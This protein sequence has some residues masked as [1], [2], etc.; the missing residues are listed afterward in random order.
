MSCCFCAQ[1]SPAAHFHV[2]RHVNEGYCVT[3]NFYVGVA[4]RFGE[5]QGLLKSAAFGFVIGGFAVLLLLNFITRRPDIIVGLGGRIWFSVSAALGVLWLSSEWF[6]PE[7]DPMDR[8][9][10]ESWMV[11]ILNC[12]LVAGLAA[13]FL[14]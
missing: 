7:R 4:R 2:I 5:R 3:R 12:M 13:W 6:N 8:T 10:G 1:C 14:E 11:F 9:M